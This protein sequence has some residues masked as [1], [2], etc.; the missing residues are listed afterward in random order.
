MS[1]D[2]A[3]PNPFQIAKSINFVFLIA[4][5]M[6]EDPLEHTGVTEAAPPGLSVQPAPLAVTQEVCVLRALRSPSTFLRATHLC[7]AK[8]KTATY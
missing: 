8:V 3:D 2:S 4:L 5:V 6:H 1:S 7:K